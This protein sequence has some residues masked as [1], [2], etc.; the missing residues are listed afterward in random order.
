MLSPQK[1]RLSTAVSCY[2]QMWCNIC[3]HPLSVQ[4]RK[5][6]QCPISTLGLFSAA[7][8]R[9]AP[10]P[11]THTT[12]VRTPPCTPRGWLPPSHS[13]S[14]S[15]FPLIPPVPP[16]QTLTLLSCCHPTH[17]LSNPGG[18]QLGVTISRVLSTA[19]LSTPEP[20]QS[21]CRRNGPQMTEGLGR[22]VLRAFHC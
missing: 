20:H 1:S 19:S 14:H 4:R 22:I 7:F 3:S 10:V 11:V 15:L 18:S 17:T 21:H 5:R 6:R 12:E 16:F 2:L 9:F 8:C 13:H